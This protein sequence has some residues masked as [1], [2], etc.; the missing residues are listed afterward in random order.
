MGQIEGVVENFDWHRGIITTNTPIDREY[1]NT[2]NVRRFFK[3]NC[4]RD[5]K[6]DRE[7]MG[8]MKSNVGLTMGEAVD[9]W[10]RR[11]S[12]E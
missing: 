6:F 2:Q 3:A 8:W 1:R 9:E 7:F 12:N 11:R 4:G 5:F 10:L